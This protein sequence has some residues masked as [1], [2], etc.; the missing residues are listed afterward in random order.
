MNDNDIKLLPLPEGYDKYSHP[1][2]Y[3]GQV[4]HEGQMRAYARA[5]IARAIAPLQAEIEALRE[6]LATL[7]A[8][9]EKLREALRE[10]ER[11]QE[12]SPSERRMRAFAASLSGGTDPDGNPYP[13]VTFEE[14]IE[15]AKDYA[16][17]GEYWSEGPRFEGKSLYPEFWVDFEILTGIK[18]PENEQHSFFSSA[19][20]GS[21]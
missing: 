2:L 12:D 13:D 21:D 9:N 5:N 7:K 3:D 11:V 8:E 14:L 20:E 19:A 10:L 4:F 6:T 17:F 15:R 16:N 18:V 1:R